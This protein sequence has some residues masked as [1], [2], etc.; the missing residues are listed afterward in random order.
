MPRVRTPRVA[1]DMALVPALSWRIASRP[2]F[3]ELRK[4]AANVINY[5]EP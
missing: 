1:D 4:R 3:G 2:K 5:D